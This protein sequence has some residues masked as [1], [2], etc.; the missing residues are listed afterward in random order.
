MDGNNSFDPIFPEDRPTPQGTLPP[1]RRFKFAA[2]GFLATM[3]NPLM[4][5]RDFTWNDLYQ[6]APVAIVTENL[7]REYWRE[8]AGSPGQADS[9]AA[10]WTTGGEIVG[11]VGERARRRRGQEGADDGLLAGADEGLLGRGSERAAIGGVTR[12]AAAGRA[13][14]D[15]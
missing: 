13:G 3:G 7:A 15:W 10:R 1:V 6:M 11:V 9:R 2:P 5:G 8:P 14:R 12:S 4:A